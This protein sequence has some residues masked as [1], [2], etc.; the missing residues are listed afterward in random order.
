[1]LLGIEVMVIWVREGD[2]RA[3]IR[4][5]KHPYTVLLCMNKVHWLLTLG[6]LLFPM[7]YPL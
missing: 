7:S 4:S 3:V 5:S 1:M 6:I 2:S